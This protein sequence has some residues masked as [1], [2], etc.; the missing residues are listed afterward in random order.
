MDQMMNSMMQ[1]PFQSLMQPM[2]HHH[3]LQQSP[4]HHMHQTR[5][6]MIPFGGLP[7]F[8]MPD[9]FGM[10][11]IFQ[12]FVCFIILTYFINSFFSIF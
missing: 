5:S 9:P 6:A 7:G 11:S 12:G 3:M 4:N 10:G 8:S 2:H 1:D